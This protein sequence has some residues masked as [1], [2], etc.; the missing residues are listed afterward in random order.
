MGVAGFTGSFWGS[1]SCL[2]PL[3]TSLHG[4]ALRWPEKADPT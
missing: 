2:I 3:L 1:Q 4:Q